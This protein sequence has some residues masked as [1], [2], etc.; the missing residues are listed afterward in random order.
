MTAVVV[1]VADEAEESCFLN[2]IFHIRSSETRVKILCFSD[3]LK[4]IQENVLNLSLT[5]FK[6]KNEQPFD[7]WMAL[8][9][10]ILAALLMA[11]SNSSINVT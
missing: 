7:L 2:R 4:I 11:H 1:V 8:L 3:K 5:I 6:K 10:V 9:T